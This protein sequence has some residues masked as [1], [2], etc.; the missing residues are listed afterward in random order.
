MNRSI[1]ARLSNLEAMQSV[2]PLRIV[3]S[4]ISDPGE[5]A[6][7]SRP[8]LPTGLCRLDA[9]TPAEDEVPHQGP[10]DCCGAALAR[11]CSPVRS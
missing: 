3:W 5:W 7:T 1:Q 11:C 4:D 2:R 9:G 10:V 8:D 6:R